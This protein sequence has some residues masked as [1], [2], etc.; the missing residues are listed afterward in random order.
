MRMDQLQLDALFLK[1][2]RF[3]RDVEGQHVQN[4]QQ[5]HPQRLVLSRR[6]R[7]ERAQQQRQRKHKR[8]MN[9]AHGR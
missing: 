6:A 2:A 1:I 4:R 8:K 3:L 7:R 5:A 9:T